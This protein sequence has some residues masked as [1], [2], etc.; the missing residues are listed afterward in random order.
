MPVAYCEKSSI[1]PA[2]APCKNRGRNG[3]ATFFRASSLRF[4]RSQISGESS[5]MIIAMPASLL[6]RLY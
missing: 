2:I 3:E 5:P 6:S 1:V 4:T